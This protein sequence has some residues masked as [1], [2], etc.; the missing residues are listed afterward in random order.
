MSNEPSA[1]G[2]NRHWYAVATW[3]P[4]RPCPSGYEL[5]GS[6]RST[7]SRQLPGVPLTVE[8]AGIEEAMAQ[9]DE[10]QVTATKSMLFASLAMVANDTNSPHKLPIGA[11]AD[12][13]I[14]GDGKAEC[15]I[16]VTSPAAQHLIKMGLLGSVSLT[17]CEVDDGWEPPK[18]SPLEMTICAAPA[19]PG[20]KI[21]DHAMSQD[22]VAAY[23]AS[24]VRC[25]IP[26][27][28]RSLTMSAAATP[29]PEAPP[30][31]PAAGG[32]EAAILAAFEAMD[33]VQRKKLSDHMQGKVTQ[34]KLLLAKKAEVEARCATLE[35]DLAAANAHKNRDI[36]LLKRSLATLAAQ[37]PPEV[38]GVYAMDGLDMT[39]TVADFD[40]TDI[41]RVRDAALRTVMCASRTLQ[42]R[43]FQ[44]AGAPQQQP[45]P[46]DSMKRHRA[47][48]GGGAAA[49]AADPHVFPVPAAPSR[50]SGAGAPSEPRTERDIL[51]E[52][53]NFAFA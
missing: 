22:E 15:A 12:S 33:P 10:A 45:V 27:S 1:A 49:G 51:M 14:A 53:L 26:A 36:E 44:Q 41:N 30:A 47:P 13:W 42:L 38:K 34:Y 24:S 32:D 20:A 23:K 25:G 31:G 21:T 6:Q 4:N 19:R 35:N 2:A 40:S 28:K 16:V 43:P 5:S 50:P 29:Q 48:E 37:M 11:V 3:A 9:I 46:D 18:L 52:T 39:A 7:L 17:Q 8:H